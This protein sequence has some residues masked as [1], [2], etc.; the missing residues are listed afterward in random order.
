LVTGTSL[1]PEASRILR[2]VC[3]PVIPLALR[4]R[5]YLLKVLLTLD[6]AQ[7]ANI[8]AGI[9]KMNE[10]SNKPKG[11]VFPFILSFEF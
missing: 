3:A 4:T 9:N 1:K 2:A 5:E 7:K 8:I 10:G 6:C 11:I